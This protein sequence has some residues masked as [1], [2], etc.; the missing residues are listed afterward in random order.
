M[1]KT[2][3]QNPTIKVS[4]EVKNKKDKEA[5]TLKE[6]NGNA[7][8]GRVKK[9][10]KKSRRKMGEEKFEKELQ[11]TISFLEELRLKLSDVPASKLAKADETK[12]KTADKKTVAKSKS[13]N[14]QIKPKGKPKAKSKDKPKTQPTSSITSTAGQSEKTPAGE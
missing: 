3:V 2:Q 12:R 4:K 1:A 7:L 5:K 11:R 10:I 9:V 6:K 13:G 14:G 8:V